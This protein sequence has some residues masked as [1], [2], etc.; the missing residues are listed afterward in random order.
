MQIAMQISSV[1]FIA[2]SCQ[3]VDAKLYFIINAQSQEDFN[4]CRREPLAQRLAV[5]VE[6]LCRGLQG[7]HHLVGNPVDTV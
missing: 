7:A 3:N 5:L 4:K 2:V 6:V 1:D